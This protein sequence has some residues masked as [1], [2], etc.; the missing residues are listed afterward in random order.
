[1]HLIGVNLTLVTSHRINNTVR[2]HGHPI[3]TSPEDLL[4][5]SMSICVNTKRTFMNF[6][7]E[8]ICFVSIHASEQDQI[9]IPLIQHSTTQEKVSRQLPESLLISDRCPFWVLAILY[10]LLDVI[11]PRFT[12]SFF[13]NHHTIARFI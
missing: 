11:K 12:V 7:D 13:I 2:F 1:M 8:L 3:I 5:H 9:K 10:I 6:F 4:C